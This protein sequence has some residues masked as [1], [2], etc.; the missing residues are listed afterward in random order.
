MARQQFETRAEAERVAEMIRRTTK[1]AAWPT[2]SMDTGR[3][4][5]NCGWYFATEDDCKKAMDGN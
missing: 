5:V 1:Q 2:Q 4:Y 3:W